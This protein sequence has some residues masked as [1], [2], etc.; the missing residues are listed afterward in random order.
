MASS[1]STVGSIVGRRPHPRR[2]LAAVRV[3][4][5][6]D[7]VARARVPHDRDGHAADRAGAGDEDVLAEHRE[8]ECRVDGVAERVEDRR[9]VLV[10][11]RPVVPDVRHRQR[12]ELGESARPLHAEPD[13]VRAEMPAPGHA[14]AAAPTDDVALAADDLARVEVAHVRAHVDDLAD[15]LVA[16]HERHRDRL[17]RPRVPRVDV[18]IGAADARLAH[19]DQDVVDPDLRLRNVL[20]PEPRLGLCFDERSHS[21][22]SS[23]CPG[24]RRLGKLSVDYRKP[25]RARPADVSTTWS[26]T[27]VAGACPIGRIT[28]RRRR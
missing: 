25:R 7:H 3:R 20:E 15:E 21:P 8:G 10:D 24:S 11:A 23:C 18:E 1:P 22:S 9:H 19:A 17:L 27:F 6:D 4:V 14:V 28:R 26:G 5:G 13:R 2:E 16:D 12:H